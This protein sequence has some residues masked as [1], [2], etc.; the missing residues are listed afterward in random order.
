MGK[1]PSLV[2]VLFVVL[3]VLARSALIDKAGLGSSL[4]ASRLSNEYLSMSHVRPFDGYTLFAPIRSNISYLIDNSGEVIHTWESEYMPGLSVYLLE[5]GSL[6]RTGRGVDNPTFPAGFGAGGVVQKIDWN[7]A[8][9][10][11]YEYSNDQHLLHH[12]IEVLPNGNVL[13]IASQYKTF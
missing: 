3:I 1:R 9:V 4:S 2:L 7:G 13:M 12:D 10:W 6:L 8:V 11:E 5:N